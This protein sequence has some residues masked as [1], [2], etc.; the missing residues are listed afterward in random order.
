MKFIYLI[1]SRRINTNILGVFFL[2]RVV[3]VQVVSV[4]GRR[5]VLRL[6]YRRH[7]C[8][9]HYWLH[10]FASLYTN[11]M[12]FAGVPHTQSHTATRR[13]C[14]TCCGSIELGTVGHCGIF[15]AGWQM[16]GERNTTHDYDF[17]GCF[18]LKQTKCRRPTT[19]RRAN[20]IV[21]NFN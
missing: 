20:E 15:L 16:R 5:L 6:Q 14:G 10:H 3:Q 4:A 12:P 7:H 21:N 17:A 18:R 8:H 1:I 13:H 2:G 9:R 19:N 11:C